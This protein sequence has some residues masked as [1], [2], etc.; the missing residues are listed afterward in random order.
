MAIP[1]SSYSE[2]AS[3][4]I[5]RYSPKLADNVLESN[6]ILYRMKE[7]GNIKLLDGGESILENLKYAENG[8]WKWYN[9][10]ETLDVSAQDVLTS[11][12]FDWKQGN[13][14]VTIPGS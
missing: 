5:E 3:T 4:T 8:T 9:G 10:Y 1:N 2:L 14:N 6:A 11:A 13:A 7:K 12:N